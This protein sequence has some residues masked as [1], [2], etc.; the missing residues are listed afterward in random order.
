MS[1]FWQDALDR[2]A[3]RTVADAKGDL[4]WAWIE[5]FN[6]Q[7][8]RIGAQD[9][10]SYVYPE[11]HTLHVNVAVAYGEGVL[12]ADAKGLANVMLSILNVHPRTAAHALTALATSLREDAA[13]R[14]V[15]A[16]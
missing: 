3:G 6:A 16:S 4:Q 9:L 14:P 1:C 7:A 11:R 5:E 12:D 13:Q 10:G 8:G 15:V 2:N